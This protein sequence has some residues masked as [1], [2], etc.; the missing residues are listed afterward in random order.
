MT[1]QEFIAEIRR[2]LITIMRAVIRKYGL[3][4][5]DFLPQEFRSTPT[6]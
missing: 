3:S 1:D 4:W 6:A 2:G 5:L